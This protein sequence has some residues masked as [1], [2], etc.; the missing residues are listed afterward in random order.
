MTININQLKKRILARQE[1]LI[2]KNKSRDR[3]NI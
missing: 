1:E 3:G 2:E